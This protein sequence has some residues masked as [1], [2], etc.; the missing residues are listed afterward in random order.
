M[1]RFSGYLRV[2]YWRQKI[3]N[4]SPIE[5]EDSITLRV[6]VSALVIIGIVATDVAAE[7][8]FSF[9]AVPLSMVGGIWSYYR[10]NHKNVAA[11]FC[12]AIGMLLAL[13]GFFGRLI[14]ELND[15]R[16]LLAE[17]LI[18]LQVL[19]SFDMPRRKDLGYSIVIGLILLGV[20]ATLSQ[21]L[22]FAPV[23]LLFLAFALP[24]LAL[25][26]RSR[27]GLEPLAFKKQQSQK[28]DI[29]AF[30][31][32]FIFVNFSIILAIGLAI[33][34][35]LPRVP[36]Y[37]LRTFPVSSPIDVKGDFTGRKIVNPGY[38]RSGN[39]NGQGSSNGDENSTGATGDRQEVDDN[40][41]Y[42]FN[43][44][45][46]QT[47]RGE[48]KPKV[49]MRVRSQAEGF[50]RVLAFDRYTGNGWEISRNDQ[51]KRL[52][53][54]P[55]SYQT[56]LERPLI[57]GKTKEVVQT[58]T[59]VSELPNL[60]PAMSYPKEI[61]FPTP[62]IAVDTEGGL[63]APVGLSKGLTYTVLS[64]VP[65]RDRTLL[66][67]APDK[68]PNN[69]KNYYLQVPA[70]ISDKVK[71][72][73]EKI[74][75]DYNR[76]RVGKTEKNLSSPY[77][78]AL[79]LA[80][81]L[82]QNYIVPKNFIEA[83]ILNDDDDLVEAFLFK[84]KGGLPDQFSTVLTVMLRSIGIPARLVAGFSPGDF[85][86]FTGM[87]VVR[88]TDAYAMTEV[89]F[90]KYGWFA[91]DPIPSHPLIPP[92]IEEIQTFSVLRQFWNWI[93]GWLP[94]PVT[95]FLNGIFGNVLSAVTRFIS[96]FF[97][98]FSQGIFG[99]VSGLTLLTSVSLFC[100]LGWDKWKKWRYRQF[101]GKLQPMERLYR[102]MLQWNAQK[103]LTKH[104]A[105]TPLEYAR[106]LNE[107][108]S[109][110]TAE[111]IEEISQAYVSWRY[112]KNPPDISSLRQKWQQIRNTAKN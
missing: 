75:A 6:L 54:S 53:R 45:I 15:T 11:K 111:V 107:H 16:L 41:Y 79:Y 105:Q 17:L 65:Y 52:K 61:Y 36:G 81:Y 76:Q 39:N 50:W 19:H 83:P 72:L 7:A 109:V 46:D 21:T 47:L 13:G 108:N 93:A 20:A 71:Q 22:A 103:G 37:G 58:Y 63:R 92:S 95:G 24:T 69:I 94:S 68:Y 27:L 104:P 29:K 64:E 31:L 12:I 101:L 38:V 78:T 99:I 102:Q 55:F 14:G 28:K 96:W 5:V 84:N 33:F 48:M 70:N 25:D 97:S 2:E 91:F 30:N 73:T 80:Q 66:S 106:V 74:L 59:L 112:G 51:V 42:G 82:K 87:Y 10:R 77:E 8:T 3:Q 1:D 34:A 100:W 18:Q 90:P 44:K 40:F 26:Y 88:N 62:M 86:P 56:F 32:K 57:I 89:Y 35:V 49:V 9:W 4:S 43:T 98:L 110:T 60:I 67:K 85:N 23:L